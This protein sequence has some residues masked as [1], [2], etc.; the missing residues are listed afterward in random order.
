MML[1]IFTEVLAAGARSIGLNQY[2]TPPPRVKEIT[3]D[4]IELNIIEE[5]KSETEVD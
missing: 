5:E 3:I 2:L 1:L 4:V